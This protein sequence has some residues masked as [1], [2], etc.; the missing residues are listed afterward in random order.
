MAIKR[1]IQEISPCTTSAGTPT[2]SPQV[3]ELRC[4]L[5]F[6]GLKA[7]TTQKELEALAGQWGTIT[8]SKILNRTGKKVCGF[9]VYSSAQEASN[10]M[11]ACS[12]DQ[13]EFNV[14][15]AKAPTSKSAH[16]G[17]K[18]AKRAKISKDAAPAK[19]QVQQ[20]VQTRSVGV[21]QHQQQQQQFAQP[22][23]PVQFAA[24]TTPVFSP[25]MMQ[26]MP[27]QPMMQ[28]N[29]L[30]QDEYGNWFQVSASPA[31]G[32]F[33]SPMMMGEMNFPPQPM[34]MSPGQQFIQ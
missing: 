8:S 11:A 16:G 14:E 22:T 4:K 34:M 31:Q 1:S 2:E 30:V 32:D 21:V 24:P 5:F 7:K 29:Q 18:K 9:I 23:T 19:K 12:N 27:H 3:P 13:V 15:Y 25:G 10:C 33:G 26:P 17:K 20:R 28:V 6:G